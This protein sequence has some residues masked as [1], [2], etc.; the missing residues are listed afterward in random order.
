MNKREIGIIE[1]QE[2]VLYEHI[3]Y[4]KKQCRMNYNIAVIAR[5]ENDMKFAKR[6]W[7]Y[8]K[9]YYIE[10]T[11]AWGRW[12]GVLNLK[13]MLN[14]DADAYML[15]DKKAIAKEKRLHENIDVDKVTF[16]FLRNMKK[17][18]LGGK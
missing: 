17:M 5:K 13:Y 10:Y 7:H 9:D 1:T 16:K 3:E 4:C 18:L 12:Y 14:V 2:R 11:E 6:C 8:S 15:I